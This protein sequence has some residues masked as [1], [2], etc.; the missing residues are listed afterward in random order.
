MPTRVGG[1][2]FM[3]LPLIGTI[4]IPGSE[5]LPT[6]DAASAAPVAIFA[7]YMAVG[8]GWLALQR[9]RRPKMIAQMQDAIANVDRQFAQVR[10]HA[11]KPKKTTTPPASRA[12]EPS[13]VSRRTENSQRI[14]PISQVS[15]P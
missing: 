10:E 3:L 1:V 5:L 13:P 4:G 2:A 9:A 7:V 11:L 12:I 8:L 6:P 14:C 15:E